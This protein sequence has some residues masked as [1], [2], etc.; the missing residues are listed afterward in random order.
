MQRLL[1]GGLGLLLVVALSGCGGGGRDAIMKDALAAMDEMASVMEKSKNADEAKPKLESIVARMK[2]LKKKE[3]ALGKPTKSEEDALK[4]KYEPEMKKV[5][6]RMEAGMK[7]LTQR[8]P[9]GIEKLLPVFM[10]M[11]SWK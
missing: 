3:D 6:G 11:S 8:D 7:Q 5:Q 4:Q 10:E 9:T 1:P 2:E